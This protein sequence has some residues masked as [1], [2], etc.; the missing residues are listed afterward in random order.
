MLA[1]QNENSQ[2]DRFIRRREILALTGIPQ[3]TLYDMMAK[4]TF[5][6]GVRI[7]PRL[8]AWR[9]S[10]YEAWSK[11]RTPGKFASVE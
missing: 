8:V 2:P 7:T 1:R 10:E 5:P 4:G 6:K 3:S 9:L 11:A